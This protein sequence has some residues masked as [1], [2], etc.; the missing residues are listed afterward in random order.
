[1]AVSARRELLENIRQYPNEEDRVRKKINA[2]QRRVNI[3]QEE[4]KVPE[5]AHALFSFI[6]AELMSTEII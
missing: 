1:M 2:V 3:S 6:A 4:R 5:N